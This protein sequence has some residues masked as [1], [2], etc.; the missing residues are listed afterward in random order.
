MTVNELMGY[1]EELD[2]EAEVRIL[3]QE[4]WPFEC[5]IRGVVTREQ[6]TA[7]CECDRRFDE[8][9][10]EECDSFGD[11]EYAAG[12]QANDV[13][14]VEGQQERYGDKRAWQLI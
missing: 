12:L 5:S 4:N 8:P 7:E 3:S 11:E 2:G 6:V 1:L 9:H 13:F 14:I 10:V